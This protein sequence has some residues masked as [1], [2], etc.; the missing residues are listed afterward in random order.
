MKEIPI[1]ASMQGQR[2][3]KLLLK[4]FNKAPKS[5]IYKLLRKKRIKLNG[6]KAE[7][8]EM[9][10]EGDILQM[11]LADETMDELMAEK[12]LIETRSTLRV[13]YEDDNIL[14][15]FKPV[16]MPV[17]G[18]DSGKEDLNS[19]ILNYLKAK[20]EFNTD[21]GATFT[22]SICNR[23]DMNTT[24][25]VSAAK[26][27]S[28]SQ[29]LNEGFRERTIEK[30]YLTVVCGR[31]SGE[32][33]LRH[34]HKKGENNK[35]VVSDKYFEGAKEIRTRYSSVGSKNGYT[36]LELELITGKSHQIRA[37]LAKIGYPIIGDAKYGKKEV[38]KE[39]NLKHQFLFAYKLVFKDLKGSLE[40]LNGRVVEAEPDKKSKELLKKLGLLEL[41]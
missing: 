5:L 10:S 9:L 15:C 35:A 11:Y 12:K 37:S 25:L 34:F 2:L 7:G 29:S 31:L 8:K 3:D 40:Y 16:L 6:K 22:P 28:A 27:L 1:D 4:L 26:N 14:V 21:K 33:E 39:L 38:N 41:L 32:G 18:G 30:Y 20:G 19:V 36:L 13:E 17:Q 23:L 24:G